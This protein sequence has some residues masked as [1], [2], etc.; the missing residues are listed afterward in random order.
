MG[1][2]IK[3]TN[4]KGYNPDAFAN[5]TNGSIHDVIDETEEGWFVK[6]SNGDDV[7]IFDYEAEE[8]EN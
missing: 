3:L 7:F 4:F 1:K 8:Y 6:G 5:L 2:R